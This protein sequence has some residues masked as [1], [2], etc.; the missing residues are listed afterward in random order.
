[1]L[2]TILAGAAFAGVLAAASLA[3]A[4]DFSSP[5]SMDGAIKGTMTIDFQTRVKLDTTGDVP[6]GSPAVGVADVYDVDIEVANSVM[7][8]GSI[9][10][11]PWLPTTIL[12]RTY[13]EGY[14]EYDLRCVLRNPNDPSKTITLGGWVGAMTL[15]GSGLYNLAEAPEGKGRLRLAIDPVGKIQGF[16][17]NFGG[18]IQG[19]VPEGAGL[20]G[21]VDRAKKKVT[22]TYIRQ[23]NG[24]A[25][26]KTVEGADP[27]EF[28]RTELA[29]GPL[30]AY[31]TSVVTN[32]ID[33]DP[34]EGVWYVDLDVTYTMEG[35]RKVDR[36]SGTI[37][38]NED[39]D[40][41]Q[42][43]IGWYDLNVRLN[44]QA[45]GSEADAFVETASGSAEDAFFAQDN[46]IPGFTGKISY[47]D[48][49]DGETVIASKVDY[50]VNAQDASKIQVMN[51]AKILMLM[52]GPFNDE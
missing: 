20:A 14:L 10:R 3:S 8:K 22:K 43:G 36:Y 6:E 52:V 23:V 37:R 38:W 5:L 46:S 49:F 7:L 28:K 34:E 30:S 12:G 31:P 24:K 27:M 33:Y 50:A 11:V 4:S 9:N 26:P 19:R 48:T 29:I 2:R 51:F 41:M 25:V 39:P 44:E 16:V 13:Q 18:E 1:M 32:S 40:R 15:D 45:A 21:F 42:N 17:A 47:V 35:E